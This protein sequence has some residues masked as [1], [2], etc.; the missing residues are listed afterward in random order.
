MVYKSVNKLINVLHVV[1]TSSYDLSVWLN[2]H[3]RTSY[4]FYN[5]TTV[6]VK[7]RTN[8]SVIGHELVLPSSK[9]M[10]PITENLPPKH[11]YCNTVSHCRRLPL[12]FA[13]V[14]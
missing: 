3:N 14:R 10:V 9:R 12:K 1:V 13:N 7:R 5:D 4:Y 11:N 8:C 6:L 2:G